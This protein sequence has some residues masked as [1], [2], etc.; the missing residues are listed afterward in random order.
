M[1]LREQFGEIDIYLFD[2]LLKG[3]F[4]PDMTLL[5]AGCG[6]GRNMVYFLRN[7]YDVYGVDRSETAVQAVRSLAAELAPELPQDRFEM[8]AVEKLSYTNDTF[9]VVI[10]NAV[11]HFAE[12]EDHFQTMVSELWRVIKPG[13]MLFARLASS[14]G[15]EQQI[16][17]IGGGRYKL[18]DGSERYLVSEEQL[19]R[20]TEK[21]YGTWLEPLK[22][23]NVQGLRCMSTW[24]IKK[25]HIVFF[26]Q[27]R[28]R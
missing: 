12:H 3:R 17:P 8:Q 21:L 20:L 16:E 14:I 18:P 25:P 7:G 5:D 1:D 9:D 15:I 22:T 10:C 13:G 2:Q 27:E 24:C 28:A 4:T 6:N 23:V 11:L 26:E 19:L